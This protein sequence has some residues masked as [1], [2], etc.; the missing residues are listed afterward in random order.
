M[1][2][3][4]NNRF[5]EVQLAYPDGTELSAADLEAYESTL[6]FLFRIKTENG[7]RHTSSVADVVRR[8]DTHTGVPFGALTSENRDTWTHVRI[9]SAVIS[10]GND[11]EGAIGAPTTD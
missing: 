4:R 6:T 7:Y 1:V 3:I 2:F 8:A 9:S 10:F 5:F 11:T